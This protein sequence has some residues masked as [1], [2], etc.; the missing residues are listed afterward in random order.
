MKYHINNHL[1]R[2]VMPN[3]TAFIG[4][5][6][7]PARRFVSSLLW[8]GTYR[9]LR[10]KYSV[11]TA[12]MSDDELLLYYIKM[13]PNV[14]VG[15]AA[16]FNEQSRYYGFTNGKLEIGIRGTID[17]F[18]LII[19]VE[20]YDES[21]VLLKRYMCWN[22]RDIL[23]LKINVQRYKPEQR[24]VMSNL[25]VRQWFNRTNHADIVFYDRCLLEFKRKVKEAG[26][27]FDEEVKHFQSILQQISAFCFS[28]SAG[29]IVVGKSRWNGQFEFSM[30]ECILF[31]MDATAGAYAMIAQHN[32]KMDQLR[33]GNTIHY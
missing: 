18:D 20:Y 16:L 14:S 15:F 13:K 12:N 3:D 2:K 7:E 24:G 23:Y 19:I 22:M 10:A 29:K 31:K 9:K 27:G 1:V 17:T 11:N 6:R 33:S 8:S 30:S 5:V 25:I 21:L 32:T 28:K 26:I 4:I